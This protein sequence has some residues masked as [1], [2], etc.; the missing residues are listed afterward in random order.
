MVHLKVPW[1]FVRCTLFSLLGAAIIAIIRTDGVQRTVD[2]ILGSFAWSDRS[3]PSAFELT[4]LFFDSPDGGGAF[5]LHNPP[6]I[7]GL[8]IV[9]VAAI[10]LLAHVA[11]SFAISCA[12]HGF[13]FP[14]IPHAPN[15]R[16]RRCIKT[17]C[18]GGA[19]TDWAIA[20]AAPLAFLMWLLFSRA[21]APLYQFLLTHQQ[22][23]SFHAP[24]TNLGPASL[25]TMWFSFFI[26]YI[27][28]IAKSVRGAISNELAIPGSPRLCPRC[29]YELAPASQR[30]PEC[31]LDVARY[32]RPVIALTRHG[33]KRRFRGKTPIS[34]VLILILGAWFSLAPLTLPPTIHALPFADRIGLVIYRAERRLKVWL[35]LAPP[36]IRFQPPAGSL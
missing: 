23:R 4:G 6:S 25:L 9:L 20:A 16:F 19:K 3:G 29:S 35:R 5:R 32:E 33:A 24:I 34:L 15:T 30:C 10:L 18:E 28:L 11:A 17:A 2:I 13:A 22:S 27:A 12:Y 31:G 14:S 7:S 8:W 1:W 26:L 21:I 36:I